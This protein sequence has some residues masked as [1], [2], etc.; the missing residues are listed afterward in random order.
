MNPFRHTL[1]AAAALVLTAPLLLAESPES[2]IAKQIDSLRT[3]TAEQRPAATIKLAADIRGLSA[4]PKKVDLAD[5]IE[6]MVTEGDQGA[7]ALQAVADTLSQALQQSPIPAKGDKI[8]MPYLDLAKL[9]RY[10]GANV[11]LADPLFAKATETLAGYDAEIEKVNFTLKDMHGKKVTLSE[12]RGK[13]VLVNFW[14]TWCPP[15]RLEMPDLDAIAKHFEPQGLV[16]LA[17]TDEDSSKVSS[18]LGKSNYHPNIL[19][20]SGGAVHKM[21]HVDG[22]PRNFLIGKDGKLLAQTIDQST[23]RQF[24]D[25]LSKADLHL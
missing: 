15:C 3:L 23:Q 13:I 9:A 17:I 2:A 19:L 6:H 14:A 18:F 4:G 12:L 24:L 5:L 20:D 8:P 21:F 7:E 1:L 10:E 16:V 11:T 25:M 22:I